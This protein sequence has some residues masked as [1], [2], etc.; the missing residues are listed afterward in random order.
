MAYN[1]MEKSLISLEIKE[2]KTNTTEEPKKKKNH[3]LINVRKNTQLWC[4][5]G[6]AT[7]G[8]SIVL[9]ISKKSLKKYLVLLHI[10]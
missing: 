7:G 3:L 1:F 4:R 10:Y 2:Q 5:P 8:N 6:E 9:E